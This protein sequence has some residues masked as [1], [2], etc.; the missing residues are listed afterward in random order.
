VAF[1]KAMSVSIGVGA[2]IGG[3]S[4]DFLRA[5]CENEMQIQ[6]MLVQIEMEKAKKN[7]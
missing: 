5:I 2:A 1:V 3:V 7:G 4:E 6:A